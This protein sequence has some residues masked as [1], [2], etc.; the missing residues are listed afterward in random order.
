MR[1]MMCILYLLLIVVVVSFAA[2]N[3]KFIPL[4]FYFGN[5][6]IPVS[7]LMFLM[8]VAGALFGLCL[9]FCRYWQLKIKYHKIKNQLQL[10]EKEIKNLRAVHVQD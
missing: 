6:E 10:I 5:I 8:F 2:L 4:N 7:M 3:A 1:I 9:F